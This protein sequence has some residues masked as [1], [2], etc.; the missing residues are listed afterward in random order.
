V[1]ID[2]MDKLQ[3]DDT[4]CDERTWRNNKFTNQQEGKPIHNIC[5]ELVWCY[6]LGNRCSHDYICATHDY[7]ENLESVHCC[8][9][10]ILS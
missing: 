7:S 8:I 1:R 6:Y 5:D 4:W 9:C 10:P 2:Y 3:D